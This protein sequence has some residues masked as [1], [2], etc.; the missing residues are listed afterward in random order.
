MIQNITLERLEQIEQERTETMLSKD[1]Q[2][3]VRELHIGRMAP[4][5]HNRASEMMALWTDQN[6][7]RN[8]FNQVIL[9]I[10]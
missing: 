1:F 2:E 7:M 9:S 5:H 6:G 10:K 3:W 8:S 4:K